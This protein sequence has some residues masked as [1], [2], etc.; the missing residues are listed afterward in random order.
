M[1]SLLINPWFNN[2]LYDIAN[3]K[4]TK[5]YTKEELIVH[6]NELK[7]LFDE[8]KI[9]NSFNKAKKG[10]G[11]S[12]EIAIFK[13]ELSQNLD[14]ILMT[15]LNNSYIFGPYSSF[16]K[17]DN[18]K[19]YIVTSPFKDRLV[20]WILYDY[21]ES[22]YEKT[23][24]YDSFGNRKAKGTKAGALR[25]KDF[26][27]KEQTKYILQIDL[28]KYFYS[29]HHD[30]LIKS[31]NQVTNPFVYKIL[32]NLISSYETPDIFDDIFK[33]DSVYFETHRKGMPIGILS[34]QIL[35]NIF[36]NST[37]HYIK[38]KLRVKYYIRY[39]DD[40][41]FFLNSK[42]E[43]NHLK[44]EIKSFLLNNLKIE[45]NPKKIVIFPISEKKPL[46][47]LGYRISKY[48]ILP[49]KRTQKRIRNA[50]LLDNK[51]ALTSYKGILKNTNSDLIRQVDFKCNIKNIN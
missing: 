40:M 5:F 42:E 6:F 9:F 24:I 17:Y 19:R 14:L 26:I 15:I 49:R 30:K 28:S 16:I 44:K 7:E 36:L 11:L 34:S 8:K 25:A 50:L 10:K 31:L 48:K 37:D 29:I 20:H 47:F 1:C 21:L 12:Q 18:K 43:A 33:K 32:I 46:D 45:I 38:E 22:I 27:Q 4:I 35:A 39:V 23:F 13:E 51:V 3:I 41:V 2:Q